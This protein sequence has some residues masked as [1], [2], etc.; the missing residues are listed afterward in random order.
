MNITEKYNNYYL[1]FIL[2]FIFLPLNLIDQHFDG[3]LILYAFETNSIDLVYEWYRQAG[4]YLH[5]IPIYIVE[6]INNFTQIDYEVIL[7]NLIIFFL[8]LFCLEIKKY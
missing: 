1:Y 3:I 4:R 7:D 8:I 5:Q 2:F 6:L